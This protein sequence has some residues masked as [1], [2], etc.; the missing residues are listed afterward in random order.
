MRG[1]ICAQRGRIA[2][3][4]EMAGE[5]AESSGE[6]GRGHKK[7]QPDRHLLSLAALPRLTIITHTLAHVHAK[8]LAKLQQLFF[9]LSK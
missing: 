7:N 8:K 3:M 5:S 1:E 4:R 6:I 2:E 9:E